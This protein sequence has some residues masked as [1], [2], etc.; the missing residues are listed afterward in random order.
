MK[1]RDAERT[2]YKILRAAEKLFLENGYDE[3]TIADIVSEIG[4][5]KGA[6][7]H[8]F[9][10][11]MDILLNLFEDRVGK[12]MEELK[13]GKN[14]LEDLRNMFRLSLQSHNIQAIIYS[15]QV[16]LK[17]PELVGKEFFHVLDSAEEVERIIRKGIEDGSIETNYPREIA[18]ITL[19]Y[20]NMRIG[21][22]LTEFTKKDFMRKMNFSR[23]MLE[24]MGVPIFT[25]EIIKD[26]EN[27]Y[28]FIKKK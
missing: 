25:D 24:S 10:S 1:E 26:A 20:L 13:P 5:T 19:L 12:K 27:L 9:K 28:D 22:F 18:E 23:D 6:I 4:M 21:I 7:Y 11:K 16:S 14:G 2:K 8:H 17:S 3:T 15:A